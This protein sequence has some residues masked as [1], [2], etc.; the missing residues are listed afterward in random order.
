MNF[1]MVFSRNLFSG[2]LKMQFI[3]NINYS[4]NN[5]LILFPNPSFI[6]EVKVINNGFLDI[7]NL[8]ICQN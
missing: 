1:S 8:G 5:R 7:L 2:L 6:L 3:L 4:C